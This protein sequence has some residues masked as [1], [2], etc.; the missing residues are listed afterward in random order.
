MTYVLKEYNNVEPTDKDPHP[1]KFTD[2]SFPLFYTEKKLMSYVKTHDIYGEVE[3]YDDTEYAEYLSDE[4][5]YTCEIPE[6]LDT[7][8]VG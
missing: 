3:V 8:T 4:N 5:E 6:A 1:D 2:K 7:F